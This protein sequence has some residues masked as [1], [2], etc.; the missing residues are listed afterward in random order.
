[1]TTASCTG[2]LD[3]PA[4][5]RGV[6]LFTTCDLAGGRSADLLR[7]LGSVRDAMHARETPV[8][9]YI[10]LQRAAGEP[11]AALSEAAAPGTRM[12]VIPERVSLSRAR[13]LLL[14]RARRDGVLA[15]ALWVAFPDD[16]AWYPPG[17]LGEVTSLFASRPLL[18]LATCR[19]GAAPTMLPPGSAGTT[20]RTMSGYGEVVRIVSS[21]TLMLRASVVEMV[22]G[23]DERLGVG[24]RI[25]GGEDLDYA[26]RAMVCGRGEAVLSQQPLVGHRDRLAWVR[27]RYFAGSLFALARAARA[28]PRIAAQV[29]RKLAVGISLLGLRELSPAELAR[30]LRAGLAGWFHPRPKIS[31]SGHDT[32]E[33]GG[34]SQWPDA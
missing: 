33:A 25:N 23:F 17:L 21:N 6:V 9:H 1:M 15:T 7:L 10:L 32:V 12:V 34:S 3:M 16:D 8:F 11:P 5:R 20:F 30:G 27:S 2:S 29:L 13:N 18:G 31:P 28:R 19:Y 24:A 14:S 26:L 4:A 22:G